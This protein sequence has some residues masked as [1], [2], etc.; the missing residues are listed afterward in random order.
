MQNRTPLSGS[1]RLKH[2]RHFGYLNKPLNT[3]M[4]VCYL[5]CHE[6]GLCCYLAMDIENLLRPLQLFYF[7]LWPIY[8]LSLVINIRSRI[9]MNKEKNCIQNIPNM[10]LK[11]KYPKERTWNNWG[12]DL[13]KTET[14]GET[15]L[16]GDRHKW[17]GVRRNSISAQDHRYSSVK[18]NHHHQ[19]THLLFQRFLTL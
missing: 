4:R 10:K 17:K 19:N 18:Q 5:D 6:T 14:D 12:K 8:W 16:L 15:W 13:G 2:G 1:I 7:H 3:R 9:K 11:G